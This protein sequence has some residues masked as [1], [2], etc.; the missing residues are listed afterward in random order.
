[1]VGKNSNMKKVTIKTF[2]YEKYLL[3]SLIGKNF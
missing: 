2:D 3:V 1:M